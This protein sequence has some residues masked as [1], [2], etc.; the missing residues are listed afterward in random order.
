MDDR[1][2]IN[3][4]L[5]SALEF[6]PILGFFAAYLWLKDRSLRRSAGPSMRA[7]SWSPRASSRLP[8]RH[9]APVEA[10]RAPESK[11]QVGDGWC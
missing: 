6:G 10:D 8:D 7:S 9:G 4:F 11:M 3:P 1:P 2:Q 5:K